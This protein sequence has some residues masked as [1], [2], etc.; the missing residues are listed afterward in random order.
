MLRAGLHQ[1]EVLPWN[2]L[3]LRGCNLFSPAWPW[4]QVAWGFLWPKE[5]QG[6]ENVLGKGEVSPVLG[7]S[8]SSWHESVPLGMP[9]LC[10]GNY[11]NL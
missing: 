9:R 4:H 6:W 2:G 11:A 3:T 7:P 8:T 1:L 5:F 10:S